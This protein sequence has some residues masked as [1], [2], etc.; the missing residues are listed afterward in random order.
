MNGSK[1]LSFLLPFLILAVCL[2]IPAR[3]AGKQWALLVG[4]DKC[5]A[6]GELKVCAADAT[7]M[8][9]VLEKI[10]YPA[11]HIT[12]L[13]DTQSDINTMP[14][15]GNVMRAIERLAEVADPEDQILFFFSGHGV[16]CNGDSFLVPTDGDLTNGINLTWIKQQFATS[17]AKEKIMI[18][19]ACHSGA[20][21]GVS[22]ITPDLKK[23][24]NLVMLLSCESNQV[25][26]PDN[27]GRH[28]VFTAAV[29]DG[30]S[31][32]A[33]NAERKVT[34]RTLAAYVH[35]NVK[36]WTYENQKNT[37]TPVLVD[38]GS[39]DIVLANSAPQKSAA[40]TVAPAP[41]QPVVPDKGK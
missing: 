29:L 20:A 36:N 3:A 2:T 12:L 6:I 41:S 15:M 28:S 31:G 22:G 1:Q 9:S 38:D 18:L 24:D 4:V 37:Q 14:T 23:A 19:D 34:H 11:K 5:K 39:K 17:E 40:A 10:G 35:A 7:A 30:L 32:K 26:W 21:K 13:V 8:K 25:S 33:A 27:H 16:T